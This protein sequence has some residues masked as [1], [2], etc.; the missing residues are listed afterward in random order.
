MTGIWEQGRSTQAPLGPKQ[1]VS[2]PKHELG[3]RVEAKQKLQCMGIP[4]FHG[5]FFLRIYVF[6]ERGERRE[7]ER[8]RNINR[9]PVARPQL[10]AH[11]F[12]TSTDRS[13]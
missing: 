10:G 4:C 12:E 8:E 3:W 9:L 2:P 1:G 11:Y 6:L 5:F 13:G 7:K